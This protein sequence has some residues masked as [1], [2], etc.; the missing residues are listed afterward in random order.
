M[1]PL[2]IGTRGSR[3][4]LWQAHWIRDRILDQFPSL[5]LELEI[6]K[7]KGDQIQDRPLSAIGGKG[8]FIKE[9]EV[10][11][12]AHR[13]DMAIHSMKDVPAE[14]PQGLE[15]ATITLRENPHDGLIAPHVARLEDLPPHAIIGTSSLRRAAQL[16]AYR[17]D[18][19]IKSLRGNVDTR[20]KK[21]MAGEVDAAIMA[22][23][24]MKRL[25]LE[26]HITQ[27]LPFSIML[28][29]IAQGVIGIET[30]VGDRETLS[31]LQHLKDPDTT[32]CIRAERE[33]LRVLE[34]NCQISIAG[35]CDIH[36]D[37][38]TL[39]A[40]IAKP[41]GSLIHRH[42]DS[43]PR[44]QAEPLGQTVARNILDQGGRDILRDFQE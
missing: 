7:T 22:V 5:P 12:M 20:L 27:V 13:T 41:D 16:K 25:G 34:G 6:I 42:Q 40:L 19:Q 3:L 18:F 33:V 8:L 44:P 39:T 35:F 17:P 36:Q 24:G 32:D 37:Q 43:A 1:R 26:A 4:A 10:A 14:L 38:L 21:V 30:R 29:A 28:P 2:R 9:L 23:A 31:Y 11:L 15:I